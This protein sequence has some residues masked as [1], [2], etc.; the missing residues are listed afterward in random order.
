MAAP[1]LRDIPTRIV[2]PVCFI[3]MQALWQAA[4]DGVLPNVQKYLK[5]G[6]DPNFF[7]TTGNSAVCHRD[8]PG[9][10]FSYGN[11][12]CG[13]SLFVAALRGK[14]SVINALLEGGADPDVTTPGFNDLNP[15][16]AAVRNRFLFVVDLLLQGGADPNLPGDS[17]QTYPLHAA[18]E[19]KN[20]KILE[21]LL[22][23]QADPDLPNADGDT[24]VHSAVREKSALGVT[25]LKA[26]VEAGGCADIPNGIDGDTPLHL[27]AKFG[28]LEMVQILLEADG[29]PT[30]PNNDGLTPIDVVCEEA[31]QN[32]K[33]CKDG[34]VKAALEKA[35]VGTQLA[36]FGTLFT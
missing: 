26:M 16:V 15:L 5:K 35:A 22:A 2:K 11:Q 8:N 14:S 34:A 24:P 33:G 10:Q 13:T 18:V 1:A 23:A 7:W 6:A 29:D 9:L 17:V 28:S 25:M 31:N 32:A 36:A 4:F 19:I 3:A 30:F 20:E 12:V 21:L 27:A